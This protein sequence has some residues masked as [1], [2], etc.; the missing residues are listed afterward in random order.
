MNPS[1][2]GKTGLEEEINDNTVTTIVINECIEDLLYLWYYPPSRPSPTSGE[3][4]R[5]YV[6]LTFII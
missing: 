3:G 2:D 6:V 5:N 4:A 1:S